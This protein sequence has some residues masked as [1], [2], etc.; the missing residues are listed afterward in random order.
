MVAV[1]VTYCL[2]T[3]VIRASDRIVDAAGRFVHRGSVQT[4]IRRWCQSPTRVHLVRL[5]VRRR[6]DRTVVCLR[7]ACAAALAV[8]FPQPSIPI[9]AHR[10]GVSTHARN[11]RTPRLDLR[12]Y[13]ASSPPERKVQPQT[14][15]IQIRRG[16]SGPAASRRNLAAYG[17]YLSEEEH[18]HVGRIR[19]DEAIAQ[20]AQS[21]EFS[22]WIAK[23]AH[24]ARNRS[25]T[26]CL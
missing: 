18:E 22:A 26:A 4:A 15:Q 14:N 1:A 6:G 19:T 3:P 11:S 9:L 17:R 12:C 5:R 16:R 13:A 2:Y 24:R 23:N 25:M 7:P 20:L 21:P 10:R 8:R